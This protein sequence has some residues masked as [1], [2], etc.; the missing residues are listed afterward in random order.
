MKKVLV[1]GS[2]N[3]CRSIMIAALIKHISFDRIEVSS[4]GINPK[5]ADNNVKKILMEMGIDISR[6]KPHSMNEFLHSK[7]DIIITTSAEAREKAK[8]LLLATTKIHKELPDPRTFKG[9]KY[10]K[11]N[12]FRELRDEINEWLNEFIPRH[13]LI[14]DK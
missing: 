5:K 7:F 14:S 8:T 11:E 6:E 10:D 3:A 1:L 2:D 13:R 9:S 12:A 4:A